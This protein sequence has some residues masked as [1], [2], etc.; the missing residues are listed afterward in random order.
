MAVPTYRGAMWSVRRLVR[1]KFLIPIGSLSSNNSGNPAEVHSIAGAF[2]C[3]NSL[4]R[5]N[6][7][8]ANRLVSKMR[9]E[10]VRLRKS[11]LYVIR[12]G[13]TRADNEITRGAFGQNKTF[14]TQRRNYLEF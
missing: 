6:I 2:R 10:N 13:S 3:D 7:H 9:D 11:D 4:R 1:S 12:F 5:H 8:F 14:S